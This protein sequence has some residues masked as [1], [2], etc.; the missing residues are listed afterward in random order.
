MKDTTAQQLELGALEDFMR[1]AFGA[2]TLRCER[3]PGGLSNPTFF[4]SFG[5][6]RMVLRKQPSGPLLRGAHAIDREYRVLA[7]LRETDIP[8]PAPI[9]FHDTP[10]VLDTPFYLMEHLEGRIFENCALPSLARAERLDIYM[11]MAETLARLHAV[12]PE[13]I[14]LGDFGRPGNYFE[15]QIE[16][17]TRQYEGASGEPIPA[18][19][20]VR[21]WLGAN[22]PA[23]DG[24]S[25]ICHGDFRMGNL[26]FHPT[27]PEVIGI[28]D[29]ELS[30]I[31]HPMADLGFCCMPWHTASDEFGGILGLDAGALGLPS[32]QQFLDQY[33]AHAHS[34]PQLEPFHVVFALFRFAVIFVGI[35]ERS[36]QGTAITSNSAQL[37]TL[38][39]RFAL[40]ALD[41]IKARRL[42]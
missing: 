9:L 21:D 41:I 2:G 27:R 34:T 24:E 31:G 4:V 33:Y 36:R 8:V 40:R 13:V 3:T 17:W 32:E 26:M 1:S 11:A 12:R 10:D 29:W 7:A 25:C 14:G 23:D 30:T 5:E 35:A 19:G 38:A 18:I 6:R 39:E 28:L 15:R 42:D 20:T 22:L 16:R 37:G